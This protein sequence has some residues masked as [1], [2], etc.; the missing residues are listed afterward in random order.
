M[1][2]L[3]LSIMMK[4]MFLDLRKQSDHITLVVLDFE[5]NGARWVKNRLCIIERRRDGDEE[6]GP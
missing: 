1:S 2:T 5:K 4:I 3:I 6:N